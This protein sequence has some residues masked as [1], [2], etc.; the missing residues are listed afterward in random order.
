MSVPP[1]IKLFEQ[2]AYATT[3]DAVITEVL[4][5]AVTLDRTLFDAESGGQP[6]D[7]GTLGLGDG[8]LLTVT[9]TRYAPG[10]LTILHHIADGTEGLRPGQPVSMAIDWGRRHAHMRLHTCLHLLCGLIDAP[11]TGG[12]I[13]AD[14][15][16]LDFDLR[17]AGFTKEELTH[18][19]MAEV[20]SDRPVS[21]RTITAEDLRANPDLVRTADVTPPKT[22]E[23][24]RLIA[25][26]G[27]DLQPCGGTHVRRTGEIGAVVINKIKKKGQRNRRISVA[28]D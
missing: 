11:V 23:T 28:L 1:T 17:E 2:D 13:G 5:E 18:K 19:V 12:A 9:D 27:L 7:T 10:R 20:R 14:S 15:A 24:V 22:G 21:S 3:A 4:P 8:R 6:G 25:I 26:E 16:R